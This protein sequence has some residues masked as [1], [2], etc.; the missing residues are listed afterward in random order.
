M[1][2][3]PD[4]LPPL[5][6]GLVPSPTL[7]GELCRGGWASPEPGWVVNLFPK[8]YEMN[9]WWGVRGGRAVGGEF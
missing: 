3:G 5:S 8:K 2:G 6:G 4:P 1:S 9:R 7:S